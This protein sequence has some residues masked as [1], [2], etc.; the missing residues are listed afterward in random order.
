MFVLAGKEPPSTAVSVMRVTSPTPSIEEEINQ[1]KLKKREVL[2]K[3]LEDENE[4][5]IDDDELEQKLREFEEQSD[6][7]DPPHVS[8]CIENYYPPD[9]LK[10][11]V[12]EVLGK[13]KHFILHPY[14]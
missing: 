5:D 1:D 11:F 10:N 3:Q 4:S 8:L 14:S 12:A 7:E 6:N 9:Q 2:K 13:F